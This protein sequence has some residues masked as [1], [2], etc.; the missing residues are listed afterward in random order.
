M[1]SWI[2]PFLLAVP[3]LAAEVPGVNHNTPPT[4][5]LSNGWLQ[6]QFQFTDTGNLQVVSLRDLHK[7]SVWNASPAHPSSPI[8]FKVDGV[9]FDALTQFQI[10]SETQQPFDGGIRQLIDLEDRAQTAHIQ[11]TLELYDNQ[12]VLR[13]YVKY[14]NLTS[15]TKYVQ[16]L[17][18]MPWAFADDGKGFTAF[19]VNQWSA[20][21]SPDDFQPIQTPV[22]TDGTP[23]EVYSGA[24][25]TQCT[26]LVLKETDGT[27]GLFTGWEFDGRART[28]VRQYGSDG[29]LQFASNILDLNH[30]VAPNT[31]FL[32][33]PAFIG[34]FDGDFDE[35]GYRTQRF[36][37]RAL[38]LKPADPN[39]PYVGWDSWVYQTN[40][41]E[42][43][44]RQ[45]ADAAAR[46]GI[47][48][49]TIDLGW[50]KM[51]GDWNEDPDKFPSGLGALSDYVHSLGMKFGVHFALGEAAAEAPV[52]QENPDWTSTENGGYFGAQSLCLSHRP[53]KEWVVKQAVRMIDEYKVDWILQDGENMVKT[54]T[55]TSHT[56]DPADSNY[57]NAVDGLNA[58][59]AEIQRQRPNVYWE[60][61]ENGGNM[62]TFNMVRQYVT[63]ITNDANGSLGAR[64]ATYGAT[65]PFP[66]RYVD[67]YM[68]ETKP[69]SYITRSYMFGG[70]WI[71]MSPILSWNADQN[72]LVTREIETFKGQRQLVS[73][74]KV[75]HHAAPGQNRIDAI[76]AYNAASD[77][78]VAVITRP[79]ATETS[80]LY[81]PRG[82]RADGMYKIWTLDGGYLDIQSGGSLMTNG[83]RVE[84]PDPEMADIVNIIPQ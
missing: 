69:T 14:R 41:N 43:T 60:N 1:R 73:S 32:V 59:V 17:N 82:L 53:V 13:Y 84:L 9:W 64:L 46:L 49:F 29:Y 47:E 51:L 24:H 35:A 56:H 27:R 18:M 62:M 54:C 28:T 75:F 79:T 65:Y 10:T 81:K 25:G 63:S 77:T 30:P 19:A 7:G 67:R 44:L 2:L 71:L 52:L 12:P 31:E 16:W 57:S 58:I 45:S 34:L 61:F 68:P 3:A 26:W 37:D 70:P 83:I 21:Q 72:A 6:A 8:R 36:V 48:L 38:A 23:V 76:S 20:Q 40:L 22:T 5:T 4:W 33:P 66:A 78:S 74:G 11:L 55:K 42:V 15:Q 39:F 50:A 80:Y